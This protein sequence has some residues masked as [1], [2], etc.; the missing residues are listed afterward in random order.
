MPHAFVYSSQV[1]MYM[2]ADV[3]YA[4]IKHFFPAHG[5]T[6]PVAVPLPLSPY[7][8]LVLCCRFFNQRSLE[9]GGP[10]PACAGTDMLVLSKRLPL[11]PPPI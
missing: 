7:S 1:T 2:P 6:F 9:H 3:M 4:H 5:I 10:F 11:C 8:I